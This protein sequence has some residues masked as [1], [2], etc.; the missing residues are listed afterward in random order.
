MKTPVGCL[1]RGVSIFLI[2]VLPI[3][4]GSSRKALNKGNANPELSLVTGL[5]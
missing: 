5:L 3:L 2:G 4:R 1:N